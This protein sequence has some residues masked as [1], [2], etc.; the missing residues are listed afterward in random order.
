MTFSLPGILKAVPSQ[1]CQLFFSLESA[2]DLPASLDRL[3]SPVDGEAIVVG[4]SESLLRTPG[5]V[6]PA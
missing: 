5:G 1:A 2:E 3:G 4:P 6:L